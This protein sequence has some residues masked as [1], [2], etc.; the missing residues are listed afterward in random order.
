MQYYELGQEIITKCWSIEITKILRTKLLG[1]VQQHIRLPAVSLKYL[2]WEKYLYR[3][4]TC[5][6]AVE[7]CRNRI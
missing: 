6:L 1:L 3:Y 2:K 7:F 5:I 4:Y